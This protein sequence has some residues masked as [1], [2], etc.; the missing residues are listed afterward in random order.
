MQNSALIM[1]S[2]FGIRLTSLLRD[3]GQTSSKKLSVVICSLLFMVPKLGIA[4][5]KA[6]LLH[7]TGEQLQSLVSIYRKP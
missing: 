5:G 2:S 3:S 6:A 7:F 4:L 1:I